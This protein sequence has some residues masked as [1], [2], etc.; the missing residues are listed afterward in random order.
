MKT[1]K[2]FPW[3][4]VIPFLILAFMLIIFGIIDGFDRILNPSNLESM[5]NQGFA[6]IISGFGMV[7]ATTMGS[8]DITHGALLGLAGGVCCVVGGFPGSIGN[9]LCIRRFAGYPECEVPRQYLH[10]VS[11]HHDRF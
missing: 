11:C 10:D 1:K 8:T 4:T 6:I 7:F 9:R 2:N 3:L 5:F